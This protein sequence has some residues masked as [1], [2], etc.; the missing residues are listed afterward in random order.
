MTQQNTLAAPQI[1]D[2]GFLTIYQIIG[3]K[4]SNPP[5]PPI[6]PVSRTTFYKGIDDGI[7]PKPIKL[8]GRTN[9]WKVQDIRALI[10]SMGG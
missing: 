4:K 10:E 3:N 9:A 5:T 8:G 2:I 1:P 6:I 7:Y